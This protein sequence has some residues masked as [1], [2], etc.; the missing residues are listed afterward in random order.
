MSFSD[1]RG[2]LHPA[3]TPDGHGDGWYLQPWAHQRDVQRVLAEPWPFGDGPGSWTVPAPRWI[4]AQEFEPDSMVGLAHPRSTQ[5][6]RARVKRGTSQDE[7][8]AAQAA[9]YAD[10]HLEVQRAGRALRGPHLDLIIFDEIASQEPGY[11]YTGT[12]F[13]RLMEALGARRRH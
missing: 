9:L 3:L 7:R 2:Q 6:I 1:P 8:S 11:S 13:H 4:P 5:A 10:E 12:M